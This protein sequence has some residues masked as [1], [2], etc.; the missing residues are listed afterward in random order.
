MNLLAALPAAFRVYRGL[1]PSAL[2]QRR[3]WERTKQ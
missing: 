2:W 1:T 3:E